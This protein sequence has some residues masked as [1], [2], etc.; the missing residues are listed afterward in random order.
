VTEHPGAPLRSGENN[1]RR[2]V[3]VLAKAPVAGRVKTRMCPPLSAEQAAALHAANVTDVLSQRWPV[4]ERWLFAVD[5]DDPFWNSARATG[6]RVT[7]QATG[8]L[9]LRIAHAIDTCAAT[10]DRVLILGSDTPQ[11]DPALAGRALDAIGSADIALTPSD[12]GGYVLLTAR[13][14][15][16][17]WCGEL[18]WG[19]DAVTAQT[20]SRASNAG[21]CVSVIGQAYDLDDVADLRRLWLDSGTLA[22]HLRPTHTLGFLRANATTLGF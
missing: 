8:H 9:G 1:D 19:T 3:A 14:S 16:D 12:D 2:A 17:A 21:F 7:E 6:W 11:L 22:P 20:I 13:Q 5:A 10:C 18:P 15:H 4:D